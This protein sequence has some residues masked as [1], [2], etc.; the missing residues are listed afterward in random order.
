M[1]T[2]TLNVAVNN[3]ATEV[4]TALILYKQPRGLILV[5]NDVW[6]LIGTS[7]AVI[8]HRV[9][10]EAMNYKVLWKRTHRLSFQNPNPQVTVINN[11]RFA[12]RYS[13]AGAG[14]ADIDTGSLWFIS[15]STVT[16][17]PDLPEIEFNS[18]VRYVG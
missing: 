13:G 17:V 8:G 11:H 4:R 3:T 9:L 2:Y 1:I 16:A 14:F 5:L 6:E 7:G 18:R 12:T 10:G 15:L